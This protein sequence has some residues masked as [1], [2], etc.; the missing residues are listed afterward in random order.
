MMLRV[1]QLSKLKCEGECCHP[2]EVCDQK[3]I[4]VPRRKAMMKM[5]QGLPDQD[6]PQW[7]HMLNE[8]RLANASN[9]AA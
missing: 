2:K 4:T 1:L 6:A 9:L 7:I 8:N 3:H 5:F